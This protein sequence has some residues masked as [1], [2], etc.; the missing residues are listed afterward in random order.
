MIPSQSTPR[1]GPSHGEEYSLEGEEE[2]EKNDCTRSEEG[3]RF[4]NSLPP[5]SSQA[6]PLSLPYEHLP[7]RQKKKNSSWPFMDEKLPSSQDIFYQSLL[8]VFLLSLSKIITH[9]T[10]V[11]QALL[12]DTVKKWN[13]I[14]KQCKSSTL[15][16]KNSAST[17][18]Y[19]NQQFLILVFE[20]PESLHFPTT[21]QE[22]TVNCRL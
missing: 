2:G 13:K 12:Q 3:G 14:G 17:Q 9:S 8:W 10:C 18:S 11:E 7:H 19:W 5:C 4:P 6:L 16:I 20:F 1:K 22:D 21:S 15:M